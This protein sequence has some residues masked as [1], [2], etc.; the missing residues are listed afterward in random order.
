VAKAAYC[1]SAVKTVVITKPGSDV[2]RQRIER[3][4]KIKKAKVRYA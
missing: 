2:R 4:Q 1:D 3:K